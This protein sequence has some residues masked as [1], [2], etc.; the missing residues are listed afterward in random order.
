MGFVS[1]AFA[2]S[3]TISLLIGAVYPYREHFSTTNGVFSIFSSA[4]S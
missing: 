1:S 3:S 2:Y 4:F